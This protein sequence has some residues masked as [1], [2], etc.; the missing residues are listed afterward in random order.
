M[1]SINEKLIWRMR[2]PKTNLAARAKENEIISRS[3]NYLKSK[4]CK[5]K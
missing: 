5:F 1:K 2:S 3:L 4:I